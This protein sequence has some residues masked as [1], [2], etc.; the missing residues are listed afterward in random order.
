MTHQPSPSTD[1]V[2]MSNQVLPCA[3]SQAT[4]LR[5]VLV[6]DDEPGLRELIAEALSGV[7]YTVCT[8][9]DGIEAL[10]AVER[11]LPDLVL[12]DVRMPRLDGVALLERLILAGHNVPTVLM[13][14]YWTGTELSG[15]PFVSKPFDINHLLEMVARGLD[16]ES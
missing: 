15:A 3:V 1:A 12:A 7:G 9:G 13:S 10:E 11:E 14:A 16:P 4:S 2:D 5:K 6:V 8:A